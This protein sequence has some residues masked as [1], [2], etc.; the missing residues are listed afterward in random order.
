MSDSEASR[1]FKIY[2]RHFE[3]NLEPYDDVVPCLER[4]EGRQLGIITNGDLEEQV[5]KLG[6]IIDR[7]YFDPV[8]AAGDVG[9]AKPDPEIFKIACE[10][11]NVH[12]GNC[13]YVGDDVEI[14]IL[15]CMKAG[16]S[17]IWLNRKDEGLTFPDVRMIRSLAELE[18]VLPR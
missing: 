8:I 11:A 16:M 12:P 15:P 9:V 3:V 17:G 6:K 5:F 7:N 1:Q 10:R 2:R 14:D 13:V 4:L 18:S